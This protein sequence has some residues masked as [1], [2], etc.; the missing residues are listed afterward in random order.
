MRF[1][2]THGVAVAGIATAMILA[3][4]PALAAEDADPTTGTLTVTRF[5]DLVPS[6]QRFL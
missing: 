5:D 4:M 6:S 1:G 2:T 3:P